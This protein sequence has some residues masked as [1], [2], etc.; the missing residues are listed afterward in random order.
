MRPRSVIGRGLLAGVIAATTLA[1]WFFI[2][3]A[4]LAQPFRTPAFL[5]A[6]LLGLEESAPSAV[7]VAAYT[8]VHYAVFCAIGVAS[9][10]LLDRSGI[11]PQ[12]LLGAVAGLLLF[13]VIF[14]SGVFVSGID[15]V[16]DVG[17]PEVAAGSLLAG[18][19]LVGTLARTTNEPAV[20][21]RE[22]LTEHRI[23]RE[24]LVAGM[25]GATAVALWF[26]VLDA[27]QGRIFFTPALLGSALFHGVTAPGAVEI[28][29]AN[30]AAYT[31]LHIAAFLIVGFIVAALADASERQPVLLLGVALLFFTFQALFMGLLALMSFWLVDTLQWWAILAANI[32]AAAVMG[33]YL[34]REHP[35]LR[36][37][38]SRE[39]EEEQPV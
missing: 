31:A 22:A 35:A 28:S 5:A 38:L 3:D 25:L 34:W 6:A 2:I 24:A 39:L 8:L 12:F 37:E 16:R 21:W 36:R 23:V 19:A 11:R 29:V 27:A 17:W 15:V 13:D 4:L 10:W 32:L 14:Y 30:V 9:A 26:L 33:G 7:G 20:N 1:A 18:F